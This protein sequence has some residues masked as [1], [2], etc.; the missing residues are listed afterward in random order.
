[1]ENEKFLEHVGWVLERQLQE[2][3]EAYQ[4]N[5]LK[6]EDFVVSVHN[7]QQTFKVTISTTKLKDLQ[8]ASPYSLDRYIWAQ[9][10]EKGLEWK[11]KNG[12]Y[13]DYVFP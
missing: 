13:L 1:M 8:S 3:D 10:K 11:D 2:W 12:N 6:L 7:N 4:V 5:V 9:L